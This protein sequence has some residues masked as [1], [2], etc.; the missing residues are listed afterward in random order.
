ML[1]PLFLLFLLA[2]LLELYLLLQIGGLIGVLPTVSLVVFTAALGAV[3]IH[4]QGLRAIATI[5]R[6]LRE[7]QLPALEMIA[8]L[9]LLIC[10]ALLLTPGFFTDAIGFLMLIPPIRHRLA[11]WLLAYLARQHEARGDASIVIEGEYREIRDDD[12]LGRF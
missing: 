9:M 5:N 10:A 7:R 3:L 8:G 11:L 12:K 6:R 4:I 1:K 2:P